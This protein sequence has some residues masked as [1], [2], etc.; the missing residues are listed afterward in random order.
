VRDLVTRRVPRGMGSLQLS[1]SAFA[2]LL[3]ASVA[4]ALVLGERPLL[5][6]PRFAALAL[7]CGLVTVSGYVLLVTATRIGE[8]SLLAPVRYTRLV[9]ALV[10]A[11][12][13][14]GER[15]D[16]LTIAGA[17][18]IVGSGCYTVWREAHL[19]RRRSPAPGVPLQPHPTRS[20][21]AASKPTAA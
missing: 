14:F 15:L 17:A 8:A 16:P 5:P 10:L 6:T 2:A 18:I 3:V 9:F 1:A 11:I 21:P 12:V 19:A 4:M 7:A 20:T 13:V